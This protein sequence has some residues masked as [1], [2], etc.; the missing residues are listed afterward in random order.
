MLVV[1]RDFN[2]SHSIAFLDDGKGLLWL[3]VSG[4]VR[5][6]CLDCS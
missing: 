6:M 5:Q 2:Y 3:S 1:P 4:H